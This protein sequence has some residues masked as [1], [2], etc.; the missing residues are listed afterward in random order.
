MTR[1]CC[2][3]ACG[4]RTHTFYERCDYISH[5]MSPLL[6]SYRFVIFLDSTRSYRINLGYLAQLIRLRSTPTNPNRILCRKEIKC[7]VVELM[8]PACGRNQ[9]LPLVKAI[10]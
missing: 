10:L 1:E 6:I 3:V 9:A 8:K 5:D 4:V 7:T 2:V